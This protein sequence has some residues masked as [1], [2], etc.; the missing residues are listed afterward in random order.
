MITSRCAGE[1]LAASVA[2]SKVYTSNIGQ[3]WCNCRTVP[4]WGIVYACLARGPGR[5]CA[6]PDAVRDHAAQVA[7]C[8]WPYARVALTSKPGQMRLVRIC[9]EM[10]WLLTA[11]TTGFQRQRGQRACPQR[12]HTQPGQCARPTTAGKQ[13]TQSAIPDMFPARPRDSGVGSVQSACWV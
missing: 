2:L 3:Q 7:H 6:G 4:F 10:S 5:Q 11:S 13:A 12:P 9:H 1:L 8:I